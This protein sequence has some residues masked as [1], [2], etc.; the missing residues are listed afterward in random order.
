MPINK[1][2]LAEFEPSSSYHIY[3]RTNNKELLFFH[4]GHRS[5]FLRRYSEILS[6]FCDT[7]AWILLP[8]H[9]H[10]LIRVKSLEDILLFLNAKDKQTIIERKF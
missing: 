2:F 6:P 1:K 7:F 5:F 10:L 9:F 8:N 4:D 3:N